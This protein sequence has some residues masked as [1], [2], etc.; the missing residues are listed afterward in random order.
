MS[1][2]KAFI[3]YDG[4]KYEV[5][6]LTIKMWKDIM[7]VKDLLDPADLFVKCL[8]LTTELTRDQIMN[9]DATE[10]KEAGEKVL[11]YLNQSNKKVVSHFTFDGVEYEFLDIHNL[12]FGQFI[13]IDTFLG[14]EESYRTQNLNELAA[15]L[16]CEKD[17]KYGEKNIKKRIKKFEELPIM[18]LEGAIFFLL[19]SAKASEEITQVCSQSKF[20]KEILTMKIILRLIGAGIQHSA[21]LLKTKYGKWIMYLIY[22]FL[23]VSI[24]SVT[25]WTI[26]RS[27]KR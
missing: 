20:L 17:T 3:E 4:K 13:D 7:S 19:S 26:I 15:Y 14:K 21:H 8:E 12:S 6:E 5:K 27:K 18:Y 2:T 23:C 9:A 25:L 16:Y 24:I 11:S 22:P 10:V 1:M